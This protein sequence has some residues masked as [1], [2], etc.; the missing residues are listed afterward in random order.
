MRALFYRF[1]DRWP[2][3]ERFGY[4]RFL[5][6]FFACGA[7]IEFIMIHL[8]IGETNFYDVYKRKHPERLI[9]V[10]AAHDSSFPILSPDSPELPSFL[11]SYQKILEQRQSTSQT[12]SAVSTQV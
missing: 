12:S 1:L 4:Y 8:T 5:P 11:S 3:K 9:P 6:L 10:K 7:A 2:G